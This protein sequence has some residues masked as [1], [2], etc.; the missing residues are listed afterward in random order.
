MYLIGLVP[1]FMPMW[2]VDD[3]DFPEAQPLRLSRSG[4]LPPDLE[5]L[6]K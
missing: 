5:A 3:S 4:G 2:G 1:F 6:N